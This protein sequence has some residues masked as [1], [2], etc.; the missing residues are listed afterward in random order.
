MEAF[1]IGV[2][3]EEVVD[4][5]G[6]AIAEVEHQNDR[7][8]VD[9]PVKTPGLIPMTRKREVGSGVVQQRVASRPD[10]KGRLR[11][12]EFAQPLVCGSAAA[13]VVEQFRQQ[14]EMHPAG[15]VLAGWLARLRRFLIG[16]GRFP[17]RKKPGSQAQAQGHEHTD[18]MDEGGWLPGRP[19][20]NS[21]HRSSLRRS[22]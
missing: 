16:L 11:L 6:A 14:V 13:V 22:G 2:Q 3:L 8:P 15:E 20:V 10:A 4:A 9:L 5:S 19:D 1:K 7:P 17:T 18:N 21:P 12:G